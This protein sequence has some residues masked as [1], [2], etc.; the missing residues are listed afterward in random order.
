[1]P[2]TR[3][4][5]G[6]ESR[7]TMTYR[8]SSNIAYYQVD[9]TTADDDHFAKIRSAFSK[10]EY[11]TGVRKVSELYKLDL[12]TWRTEKVYSGGRYIREF[13]VTY[14]GKRIAMVTSNDDTVI[15]SEGE[16][17]VD[18]LELE[19]G[20][21]VTPDIGP[22][23]AKAHT[24]HAWLEGLSWNLM[25]DKVALCAIFDGH[26]TELIVLSRGETGWTTEKQ[27]RSGG[28]HV[29]GYGSPLKWSQNTLFYVAEKDGRTMVLPVGVP[30]PDACPDRV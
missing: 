15:R 18:I 22:Y 2:I 26:P 25:G 3:V 30:F 8:V 16:S 6:S 12:K 7:S 19:S 24:P 14:E 1:M 20:K 28:V 11:G 13:T 23:R 29:H 27:S 21:I 5:G 10:V 9:V 17:R 4:D